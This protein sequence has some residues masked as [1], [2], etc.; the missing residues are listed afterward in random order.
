MAINYL[1]NTR[2]GRKV[3]KE[4]KKEIKTITS[5]PNTLK[6][7]V[8]TKINQQNLALNLMIPKFTINVNGLDNM[9]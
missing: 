6:P 2:E 8:E 1:T 5:S 4:R 7:Q 9:V 3:E